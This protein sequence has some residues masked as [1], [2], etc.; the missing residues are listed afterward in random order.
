MVVGGGVSE[1]LSRLSMPQQLV[2]Q[3]CDVEFGDPGIGKI[4]FDNFGQAMLVLFVVSTFG[5]DS[6]SMVQYLN[7]AL[8][9]PTH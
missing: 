6:M 7:T 1:R 4:G 9:T 5:L 2:L 8:S 3:V